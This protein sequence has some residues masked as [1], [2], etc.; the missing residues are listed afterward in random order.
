MGQVFDQKESDYYVLI[1]NPKDN[2]SIIKNWKQHYD[3]KT[4][5]I[6]MYVVNSTDQLNKKYITKD[7]SNKNPTGYSDLKVKDPTLIKISN[8]SVSAYIE[9]DEQIVEAL[10]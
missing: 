3:L 6:K 8:K 9:G 7:D 5:G 10:K 4:D 2:S 1:Y